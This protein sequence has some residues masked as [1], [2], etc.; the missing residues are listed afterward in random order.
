MFSTFSGHEGVTSQ[1]LTIVIEFCRNACRNFASF[2]SRLPNRRSLASARR[3]VVLGFSPHSIHGPAMSQWN[4]ADWKLEEFQDVASSKA[5][6]HQF[7]IA[8]KRGN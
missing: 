8:Q 1:H 6:T 7:R 2:S 4:N 5:N 3:R